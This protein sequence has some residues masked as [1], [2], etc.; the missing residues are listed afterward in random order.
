MESDVNSWRKPLLDDFLQSAR[1]RAAKYY[2]PEFRAPWGVTVQRNCPVFHIVNR[3]S[4]WL[5][6]PGV[7]EPTELSEGDLIVVAR[8]DAHRIRNLLSTP[9]VN[10]FDLIE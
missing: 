3:G 7:R 6:V 9:V 2:R 1:L 8:G 4:C 5:E 10:F